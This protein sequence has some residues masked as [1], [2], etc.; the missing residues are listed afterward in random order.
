MKNLFLC[1]T[2]IIILTSCGEKKINTN[3][4]FDTPQPIKE[5]NLSE[6]PK[7]YFGTYTLN[8]SK[9]LIINPKYILERIVNEDNYFTMSELDSIE[10]NWILKNGQLYDIY[11]KKYYKTHISNDTIYF[12]TEYL[13][14]IFSFNSNEILREFKGSLVLNYTES[15]KYQVS[16]IHFGRV[17]KMVELGDL[18]DFDMIKSELK[19]EEEKIEKIDSTHFL[20]K[21]E[22]ADFRKMH[23]LDKFSYE[24]FYYYN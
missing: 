1:I 15:G 10:D 3:I 24:S 16:W 4:Y 11:E 17:V 2:A 21:F 20:L 9:Q 5:K 7:K 23:R 12:E 19:L 22:Q 6:I 14:T 13:D 8:Y 18:K